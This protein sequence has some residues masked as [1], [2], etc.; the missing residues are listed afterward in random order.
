MRVNSGRAV[1]YHYKAKMAG[2][3]VRRLAIVG[4]ACIKGFLFDR[5]IMFRGVRSEGQSVFRCC[6]SLRS[7]TLMSALLSPLSLQAADIGSSIKG[8]ESTNS[9][10]R[11]GFGSVAGSFGGRILTDKAAGI[12]KDTTADL[13]GAVGGLRLVKSLVTELKICLIKRVN[14]MRRNNLIQLIMLVM[15]RQRSRRSR[16]WQRL[17]LA[18]SDGRLG[19][20]SGSRSTVG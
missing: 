2:C 17:L 6:P 3:I 13:T 9:I 4:I 11:A 10:I 14:Q 19:G 18:W 12:V 20:F 7:L 8:E 16:Y 1:A 15:W 5:K